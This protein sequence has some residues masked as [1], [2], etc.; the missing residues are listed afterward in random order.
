LP[1]IKCFRFVAIRK[2]KF[3]RDGKGL[4]CYTGGCFG[5]FMP[6]AYRINPDT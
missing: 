1:G 6:P 3:L 4:L 2:A 5:A